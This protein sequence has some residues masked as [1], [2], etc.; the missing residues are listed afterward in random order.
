MGC[1]KPVLAAGRRRQCQAGC[2]WSTSCFPACAP[3]EVPGEKQGRLQRRSY[4]VP[5]SV[6]R[7]G[8]SNPL[9]KST[10]QASSSVAALLLSQDQEGLQVALPVLQPADG[11]SFLTSGGVPVSA[12][13]ASHIAL[14]AGGFSLIASHLSCRL[15][16]AALL[17]FKH[18]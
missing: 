16:E 9:L 5:H 17:L 15:R 8:A 6:W 14:K 4:V 13:A 1:V 11:N 3:C 10:L 7:L 12:Y 2:G 18:P